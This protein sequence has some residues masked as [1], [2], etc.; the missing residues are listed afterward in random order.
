MTRAAPPPPDIAAHAVAK[1]QQRNRAGATLFEFAVAMTV[2]IILAS[3]L[4]H[5]VRFYQAQAEQAAMTRFVADL[6]SVLHMKV[7]QLR[8]QNKGDEIAALADQNPIEWLA[9]KPINYRGEWY[10]PTPKDVEDGNWYFD[11]ASHVLVYL[12]RDRKTFEKPESNRISFKVELSRLP[13]IPA[14]PSGTPAAQYGVVLNQV[15]G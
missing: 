10:A 7:A 8:A 1:P 2:T 15:N 3:V 6:R 5:R 12:I 4:L 11:R 9:E 13:T 14:K